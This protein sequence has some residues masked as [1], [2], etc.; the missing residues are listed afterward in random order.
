LSGF[1]TSGKSQEQWR[2]WKSLGS[3][4]VGKVVP[5]EQYPGLYE[6]HLDDRGL[7]RPRPL[8]F[9]PYRNSDAPNHKFNSPIRN[10][11]LSFP[12]VPRRGSVSFAS[13]CVKPREPRAV[14]RKTAS[15]SR[16]P[17]RRLRY[18]RCEATIRGHAHTD[19][20]PDPDCSDGL[21]AG[22]S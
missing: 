20:S 5:S 22:S 8:K 15:P 11:F 2:P 7:E 4:V 14:A 9:R 12:T 13:L 21:P 3:A 17:V 1:F 18:P 6:W 19:S 16:D 10:S